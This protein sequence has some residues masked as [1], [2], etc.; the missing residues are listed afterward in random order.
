MATETTSFLD[1]TG[2]LDG[3]LDVTLDELGTMTG[4]AV[5][6]FSFLTVSGTVAFGFKAD[7][8]GEELLQDFLD[9]FLAGSDGL[10]W[11][12]YSS[13]E[14]FFTNDPFVSWFFL[15]LEVALLSDSMILTGMADILSKRDESFPGIE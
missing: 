10:S 2:F 5:V 9:F 14:T 13:C 15:F 7:V 12:S 6:V 3:Q 8:T 1:T 11:N 4:M